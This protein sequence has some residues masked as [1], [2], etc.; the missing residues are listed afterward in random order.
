MIFYDLW[1]ILKEKN[2]KL[3]TNETVTMRVKG[4]EKAIKLAYDQGYKEGKKDSKNS[5]SI[6]ENMF[7]KSKY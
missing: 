6:F 1:I 3:Q 4:F 2:P 7:G 5:L